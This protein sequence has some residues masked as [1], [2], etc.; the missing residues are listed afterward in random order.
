ME[1][2]EPLECTRKFGVRVEGTFVGATGFLR[3]AQPILPGRAK[4][5]FERCPIVGRHGRRA[6]EFGN[7]EDELPFSAAFVDAAKLAKGWAI[8]WIESSERPIDF[9]GALEVQ[10][11]LFEDLAQTKEQKRLLGAVFGDRG[12][13]E[14]VSI[15]IDQGFPISIQEEMFF[16]GFEGPAIVGI[17]CEDHLLCVETFGQGCLSCVRFR[18]FPDC[19]STRKRPCLMTDFTLGFG[20]IGTRG[21][22]GRTSL[23]WY[24]RSVTPSNREVLESLE[25][26]VAESMQGGWSADSVSAAIQ[27]PEARVRVAEGRDGAPLGFVLA[28]RIVDLLEIDLVGVREDHRRRG[29]ARSLLVQ[30]IEDETQA[31]MAEARLEL[32]ASNDPARG[33]YLGLGFMVVGRR[34]RYYPDGD[35]ALLLSRI[36]LTG[37]SVPPP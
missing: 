3:I 11:P 13:G 35:D 7:L 14:P 25:G 34:K 5:R 19:L 27:I 10:N 20:W 21:A 32:A 18:G 6:L 17:A 4:V 8:R 24:G 23:E 31:G 9:G 26:L 30:L 15:E 1:P 2:G 28:R 29:I 22:S 16:K 37:R 12:G 33:L 36:T